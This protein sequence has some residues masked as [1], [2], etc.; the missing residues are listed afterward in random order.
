MPNGK[1][2]V[3]AP[4]TTITDADLVAV[5]AALVVALTHLPKRQRDA[6][7]LRYLS[8]L[9]EADTAAAM[10]VSP[11]T[12]KTHLHRGLDALRRGLGDTIEQELELDARP[13]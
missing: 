1:P 8:D 3:D 12:V 2:A 4:D 13:T 9:S 10:G 6:I 11:G 5:R 7:A